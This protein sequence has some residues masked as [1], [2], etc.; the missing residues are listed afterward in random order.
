[1][2]HLSTRFWIRF[3]VQMQ[4]DVWRHQR[5]IPIRFS[6]LPRVSQ[7]VGHS[8]WFDSGGRPERQ[9]ADGSHVLFKLTRDVGLDGQVP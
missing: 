7:Q 4:F 9:P 1:M 6:F 3:A 2:P 5:L 8:R